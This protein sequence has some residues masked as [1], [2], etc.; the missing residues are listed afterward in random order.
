MEHKMLIKIIT[1]FAL[2]ISAVF[3]Q[4]E[5]QR[6]YVFMTPSTNT[7]SIING[8]G[9]LDGLTVKKHSDFEYFDLYLDTEN[10]AL[11]KN[12]LSLRIRKRD[13]GNGEIAYGIQLK[14]EMLKAGDIR[15]EIDENELDY[16]T[17]YFNGKK[18]PLTKT[19]ETIY[20]RFNQIISGT[21][22]VDLTQDAVLK[23]QI[24]ILN[25]WLSFKMNAAIA[26]FQKLRNLK[27]DRTELAT[28][29]PLLLG[30]SIRARSHVFIDRENTTPDLI[31][32]KASQ[33]EA[34]SIPE[35]LQS[36]R[37]VWLMESSFDRAIFFGL[38]KSGFH[39]IN[40]Y[41]V[42]N[43]YRPLL[44]GRTMLDR[45]ELQVVRQL[46]GEINLESKY[47]QSMKEIYQ[48]GDTRE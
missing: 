21:E 34:S 26:P 23:E 41:E 9:Q 17:I 22:K 12:K 5:E 6:K 46:D 27:I 25:H 20:Q 13:Y 7:I 11:I 18:I 40:E 32:F 43:K 45:F 3:A 44:Q 4:E 28:L 47:L 1:L 38:E 37:Y 35:M 36:N 19:L 31:N 10:L 48:L 2:Y 39:I 16:M 29:R 24:N 30:K 33:M 14:S 42:E 15:M 8:G